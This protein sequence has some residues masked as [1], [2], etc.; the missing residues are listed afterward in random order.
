[1]KFFKKAAVSVIEKILQ[2]LE[3]EIIT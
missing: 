3:M 2:I 1:M